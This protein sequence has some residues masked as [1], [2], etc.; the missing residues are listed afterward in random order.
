M[1]Q[2]RLTFMRG[3]YSRKACSET[4]AT[5]PATLNMGFEPR[6]HFE[7]H[8][9]RQSYR[10]EGSSR[11]E[12][13]IGTARFEGESFGRRAGW[14]IG[15]RFGMKLGIAILSSWLAGLLGKV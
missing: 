7:P 1:A 5:E 9:D 8:R 10:E 11:L 13:V 6:P 4:S 2:E 12:T 15:F 14:L 3:H